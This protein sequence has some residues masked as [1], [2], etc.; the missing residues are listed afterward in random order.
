[1]EELSDAQA[2]WSRDAAIADRFPSRRSKTRNQQSRIHGTK[3]FTSEKF[4]FANEI[5]AIMTTMRFYSSRDEI[6][7]VTCADQ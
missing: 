2:H 1:M 3:S 6:A 4:D 7:H 5:N